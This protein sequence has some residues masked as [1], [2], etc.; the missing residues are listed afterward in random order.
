MEE[1]K[2]TDEEI[3]MALKKQPAYDTVLWLEKGINAT[4]ILDLIHRLQS[5]NERL[6]D[7]KFTQ[8]H[9]DLYKENEWI[10]AELKKELAEHEEFTQK[11]K[12]EIE[13]LT[14]ERNKYKELYETMYRKWSDLSDKEFTCEALR[15]EKNEYFDKAVELQQQVDELKE[16]RDTYKNAVSN[17]SEAYDLGYAMGYDIAVK[18]TAKEILQKGIE[19]CKELENKYSHLCK[20]KKE[21]LMETCRYEGVLAVKRELY[22]LAKEKGVEVE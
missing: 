21:C 11:A 18:D 2:I 8:E 1:K 20:S 13:R 9:C 5:E 22:E 17:E 14:E 10:K 3:I 16:E 19:K 4:D 15:K 6:N 12:A 7:M